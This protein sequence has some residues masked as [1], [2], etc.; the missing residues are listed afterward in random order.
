MSVKIFDSPDVQDFL[1]RIS[2][3]ENAAGNDRAKQ[4]VHRLVSAGFSGAFALKIAKAGGLR[5]AL[6][7]ARM[8]QASG[9]GL[10]GGTM[11]EGTIGTAASLHAWAALS[12]LQWGT[13]MFGPLLL[14]DDIVTEG[15]RYHDFGV[16]L[17]LGPGLGITLDEDRLRF[18]SRP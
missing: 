7:L 3:L 12:S 15:L 16:D 5:G 2:G 10:Y 8:A 14:K 18:Y 13:E 9:I 4:I 1:V 17:P 6:A 11:L